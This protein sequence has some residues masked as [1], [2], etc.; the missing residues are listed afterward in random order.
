MRARAEGSPED[1]GGSLGARVE[2]EAGFP[3]RLRAER[4][5]ER[6]FAAP[7]VPQSHGSFGPGD[8]YARVR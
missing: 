7:C 6:M 5:P 3:P 1:R 2:F 4:G 8:V